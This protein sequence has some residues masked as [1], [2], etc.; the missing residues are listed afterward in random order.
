MTGRS[1]PENLK[2]A[3]QIQAQACLKLGSP[4]T[5]RL[6]DVFSQNLKPGGA[7]ANKLFSWPGDVGPFG[8]SLPLR[9]AGS[10]HGLVLEGRSQALGRVFPPHHQNC[11]DAIFWE[12][13]EKALYDHADFIVHRLQSPPQTNEVRRAAVMLPGFLTIAGLCKLPLV[14]SEVGASAGLNLWWDKYNY[15]LGD[16]HW[17]DDQ[18]PVRLCP[19]WTGPAPVMAPLE[20]ISRAGCDLLPVDPANQFD[21]TRMLSYIWA[22]QSERL[23]RTRAALDVAAQMDTQIDKAD[24]LDWLQRR[25][26]HIHTNAVHVIHNTIMWQ[27]MDPADQLRGRQIIT[28][29]GHRASENAPLAWLRLEADGQQPGAALILTLW[30]G[31]QE[32]YLARADF[33]GRWID[34][35]G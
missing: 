25:L 24:A 11:D 6:C 28:A 16:S 29:A 4:F 33:H 21:R 5:S 31:G 22:D 14:L 3:F 32:K 7:V 23:N 9:L 12:A 19:K 34:W 15:R 27:Y 2:S 13:L 26:S 17:G 18:S 8:A 35:S 20:V 1:T 10:L 30:P